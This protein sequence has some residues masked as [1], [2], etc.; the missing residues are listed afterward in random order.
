[1]LAFGMLTACGNSGSADKAETTAAAASAEDNSGETGSSAETAAGTAAE[2]GSQSGYTV[3][4]ELFES[5][6]KPSDEFISSVVDIT[7]GEL[8]ALKN[9]DSAAFREALNPD[10][11][12]ELGAFDDEDL[13]ELTADDL[14][15]YKNDIAFDKIASL[16]IAENPDKVS[17]S[18]YSF[19][20]DEK[21]AS[22]SFLIRFPLKTDPDDYVVLFTAANCKNTDGETAALVIT[23]MDKE[24]FEASYADYTAKNEQKT[25]NFYAKTAYFCVQDYFDELE[26][27][28]TGFDEAVGEIAGKE[29]DLT[30]EGDS[31][32]SKKLYD[33][34]KELETD[35]E[36]VRG[37]VYIDKVT[38]GEEK[39]YFVQWHDP[40]A[41]DLIGQYPQT[42][43]WEKHDQ[44]KWKQFLEI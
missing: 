6:D 10:L 9:N 31:E 38:L 2:S 33:T 26:S 15:D 11:W 25:A 36:K 34:F 37:V 14:T 17:V 35:T 39:S 24:Q 3:D 23:C 18:T 29:Y 22:G 40:A 27:K 20:E 32:I 12:K 43:T 44:V 8:A 7:V 5:F 41:P 42:I 1:M 13:K 4:Y 30:S 21:M 16:D 19:L 28:G